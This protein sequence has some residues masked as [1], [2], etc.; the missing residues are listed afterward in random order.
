MRLTVRRVTLGAD[1]RGKAK[2]SGLALV[3]LH[4]FP[5]DRR[6]WER[7]A[8]ELTLD[9]ETIAVDFPGL[10]ESALRGVTVDDAADDVAALLDALRL[11]GAVLCGI[12]MGGYVA[13]AFAE[14]H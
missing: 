10:G 4:A 8:A 3:L 7:A 9:V 1:R 14:R 6:M 5:L 11:D 13:L 12:S 2:G